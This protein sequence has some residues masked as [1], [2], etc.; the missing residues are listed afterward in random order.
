MLIADGLS[1][2]NKTDSAK[3]KTEKQR[4]CLAP[5]NKKN[6]INKKISPANCGG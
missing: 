4:A 6:T 1:F 2:L 3:Y 5:T